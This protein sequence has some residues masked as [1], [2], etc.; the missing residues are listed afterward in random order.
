MKKCYIC[1][2]GSL[3]RKSVG[4]KL[5]GVLIGNFGAEVCNKCSEIFFD[6][7]TSKKMTEI[8]KKKGL[9][10]LQ[11]KTKIGQ[12]GTTLD[13]RLPKKIIEFLNLKKGTEVDIYPEGKNKLI[14]SI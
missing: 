11:S 8:A 2:T 9:W 12:A 14:I 1:E 7:E 4:Y 10:G 13:I 3:S 6:E 5:Y